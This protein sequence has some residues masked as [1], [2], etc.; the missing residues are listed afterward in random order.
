MLELQSMVNLLEAVYGH[1]LQ[2]GGRREEG[3]S[4]HRALK[5]YVCFGLVWSRR[6]EVH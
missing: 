1:W 3:G 5:D 6:N 4:K 2:T